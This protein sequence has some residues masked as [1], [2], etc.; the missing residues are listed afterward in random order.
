MTD[1]DD[2]RRFRTLERRHMIRVKD[3]LASGLARLA[4]DG[5]GDNRF[6]VACVEYLEFIVGRFVSQG[7]GT[8]D[9]LRAAIP[10][11][12]AEGLAVLGDI[13][14]TLAATR[15]Q[16]GRLA[17]ARASAG[18]DD[19]HALVD[20]ARGFLAFY[21]GTLAQRK[22]P[23]QAIVD[24]YIDAEDY[25]RETNDVTADTFDTERK[26]FHRLTELAPD[27]VQPDPERNS[28]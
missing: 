27:I 23:A 18:P 4:A 21:G 16:L 8:I 25:W 20:A 24:R 15:Q 5:S 26:L 1:Q 19:G 22:D 11:T 10:V 28:D 7:R 12:D 3:A 2:I 13:E 14:R 6:V 17:A 9:R